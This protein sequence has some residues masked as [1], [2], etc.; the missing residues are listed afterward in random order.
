MTLGEQSRTRSA[1]LIGTQDAVK[2][3]TDPL[4]NA[5]IE[6][7]GGKAMQFHR[8]ITRRII[9][10]LADNT[11]HLSLTD[12]TTRLNDWQW[13]LDHGP[14]KVNE[15][16]S[17]DVWKRRVSAFFQGLRSP[18]GALSDLY[19]RSNTTYWIKNTPS[20]VFQLM[21]EVGNAA[22]PPAMLYAVASREGMVDNY[23]RGQVTN[24]ANDRLSNAQL[25]SIRI[26]RP[27]SGFNALGLD[28]FFTELNYT[29][30]PLRSFFP[31]G[32]LETQLTE[33]SR[34]NEFG[35]S[36]RSANAPNLRI[37]L[38]ALLSMLSRRRALFLEDARNLGYPQPTNEEIVYWTYV[39]YNTGPG[40]RSN[41]A[42]SGDGGYQTLYRH[43]PA[44][45]VAAERR[46]SLSDW[47][48]RGDEYENAIVVYQSYRMIVDSGI[49]RG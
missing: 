15:R 43:R 9:E 49:L 12:K 20:Q 41:P 28:T 18:L 23:I 2:D 37:G 39:Y 38:Q 27:V 46:S 22:I 16:A 4:R 29:T 40:N 30:Q 8:S 19:P 44:N 34:V 47:I 1:E 17:D 7:R 5:L 26:D 33:V 32:F 13:F 42:S 11:L 48:R 36:V 14:P 45:P 25:Q 6:I 10:K 3:R 31:P 24:P 21:H 35:T